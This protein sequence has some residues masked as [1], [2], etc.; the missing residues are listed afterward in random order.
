MC[1][2]AVHFPFGCTDVVFFVC[3]GVVVCTF[4][5]RNWDP[6]LGFIDTACNGYYVTIRIPKP[7]L[8]QMIVIYTRNMSECDIKTVELSLID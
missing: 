6:Y 4:A 2:P 1:Q 5:P 3:V 8:M 7:F